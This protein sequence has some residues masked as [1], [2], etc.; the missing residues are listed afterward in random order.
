LETVGR[1]EIGLYFAID[2]LSSLGFFS[3][4]YNKEH[5]SLLVAGRKQLSRLQQQVSKCGDD[6]CEDLRARHQQL[7]WHMSSG[8]NFDGTK[9]SSCLTSSTVTG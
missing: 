3:N 2:E 1:F 9:D 5:L 6:W 8:N 4:K 7:T